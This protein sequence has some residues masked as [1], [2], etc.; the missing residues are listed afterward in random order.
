MNNASL[1]SAEKELIERYG[2]LVW[3]PSEL[4][5][6]ICSF[7]YYKHLMIANKDD[8]LLKLS[9]NT[10][11]SAS[12]LV[13]G[14][15]VQYCTDIGLPELIPSLKETYNAFTTSQK[16]SYWQYICKA[17][18][19]VWLYKFSPKLPYGLMKIRAKFKSPCIHVIDGLYRKMNLPNRW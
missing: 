6:V 17:M 2:G 5:D 3:F 15:D 13:F 10:G 11:D 16:N 7:Y 19:L 12:D 4:R 1:K 8:P 18:K 9:R 14:T